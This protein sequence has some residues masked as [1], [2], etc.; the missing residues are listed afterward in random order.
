MRIT[1]GALKGRIVS[2]PKG[3]LDVRPAM[4]RM[5]E[6]IFAVLG[7]LS[8]LAFLDLFSG[9]GVVALEAASRGASPV[10]CVERDRAK[11]RLLIENLSIA[12]ERIE[13]HIM[14][15][16]LFVKR[17]KEKFDLVFCDPPFPYRFR[18][19]LISSIAEGGMLKGG[20]RLL[21]H[22][23]QEDPLPEFPPGLALADERS[24]GRS[25]VKIYRAL[26]RDRPLL[27]N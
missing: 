5:R 20:G 8:G 11:R 13:C 3:E 2:L 18:A 9:S 27:S 12:P 4:D 25:I 6:S 10:S 15:V 23:P 22:H 26:D 7:D 24:Y 14:P 1:G 17:C 16:E 19:E 21:I